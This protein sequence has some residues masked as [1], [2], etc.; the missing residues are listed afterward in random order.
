M[1]SPGG[2]A[3]L[4]HN[5]VALAQLRNKAGSK[6]SY[7]P[8]TGRFSIDEQGFFQPL[9]RTL[10]RDSVTT[11]EYFGKPIREIF[12]A[13]QAKARDV[14]QALAGLESLR[15]SYTEEKLAILNAVIKDAKPKIL[16][17]TEQFKSKPKNF[18]ETHVIVVD[19]HAQMDNQ[20]R[21][22]ISQFTLV[23]A[24]KNAVLLKFQIDSKG[25]SIKAYWLPWKTQEAT[26]MDLGSD[27]N[28]FFTSELTNCRFSVL[29]P[30]LKK[31]K[32]AHVAGDLAS[33][34]KR[35]QAEVQSGFVSKA[36]QQLVRRLS[37]SDSR[38][39]QPYS[40][41]GTLKLPKIP[42]KHDYTGQTGDKDKYSSAFVFGERG[43]DENWKFFAQIVKGSMVEGFFDNALTE[44]LQILKY[45][46]I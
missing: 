18:L 22:E 25:D 8:D 41:P 7:N 6:L 20:S 32:V 40:K 1:P 38:D 16:S 44:N 17:L 34:P 42:K 46:Q 2:P 29:D 36:N 33:R 27:A 11:E 14:T 28:F 13:A 23:A 39:V 37:I 9:I 21:Q 30:D 12:A 26:S 3:N 4:E 10:W 35:D 43:E 15:N 19:E 5:L 31:P 24:D 45:I